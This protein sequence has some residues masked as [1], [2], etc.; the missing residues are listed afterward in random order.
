M[1]TMPTFKHGGQRGVM[2][3]S[4]CKCLYDQVF[5]RV[6]PLS[7]QIEEKT[8]TAANRIASGNDELVGAIRYKVCGG[9]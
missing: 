7:E 3:S 4:F 2:K 9:H 8:E 6:C 5:I 1:G